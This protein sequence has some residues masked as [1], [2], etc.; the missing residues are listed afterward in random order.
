MR[1]RAQAPGRKRLPK[2]KADQ[3][4]QPLQITSFFG[5]EKKDKKERGRISYHSAGV[6]VI[7]LARPESNTIKAAG[8]QFRC[9]IEVELLLGTSCQ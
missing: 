4:Q 7:I 6:I 1:T 2:Q 3:G 5:G 8:S 9:E